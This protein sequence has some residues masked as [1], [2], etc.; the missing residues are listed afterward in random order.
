M[1]AE[2]ASV[3]SKYEKHRRLEPQKSLELIDHALQLL[4]R[5]S[6]NVPLTRVLEVSRRTGCTTYDSYYIALAEDLG[7]TLYTFDKEILL[8]CSYI[9]KKP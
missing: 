2:F 5:T 7:T 3:L 8:K 6:F 1:E 4:G 9:A